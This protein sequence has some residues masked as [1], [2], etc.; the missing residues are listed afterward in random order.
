MGLAQRSAFNQD[1]P[2][3]KGSKSFRDDCEEITNE[4]SCSWSS[5]NSLSHD[6]DEGHQDQDYEQDDPH[7]EHMMKMMIILLI[8]VMVVIKAAENLSLC[9][10]LLLPSFS[11][12]RHSLL[13]GRLF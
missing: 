1:L 7:N 10:H 6:N 2:E 3:K 5:N 13:P 8:M 4:L 9:S 12:D 11:L